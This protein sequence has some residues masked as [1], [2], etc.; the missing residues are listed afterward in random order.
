MVDLQGKVALVTGSSMGIGRTIA[1]ELAQEGATV[2]LNDP[3]G[4]REAEGALKMI[5]DSGCKADYIQCD[6]SDAH[7]VSKMADRIIE[8]HQAIDILVNNAAITIDALTI[9]YAPDDWARMI[10]VNLNGAFLCSKYCLP[11]MIEQ[12]W[13]RIVNISTVAAMIGL[14]G[15]PAYSASKAGLIGFTKSL[16]REV[17]R[18]GIT[19]NALSLGVI[20][21]GGMFET[22]RKEIMA[23]YVQ[24]VPMGRP[25]TPREVAHAIKFLISDGAA[26]ITGQTIGINGGFYM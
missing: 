23:A 24:Q 3:I 6:V 8:R 5:R 20:K 19:V 22:V 14:R 26:Y 15:A 11:P 1:I 21:G 13:G 17:A 18:K 12:Q 7:A 10:D 25:G 2:V 4:G 9:N 16:A